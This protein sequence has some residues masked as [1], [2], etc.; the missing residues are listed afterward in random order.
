[1]AAPGLI[2]MPP[3]SNVTALPTSASGVSFLPPPR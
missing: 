3:V 1:M 2:E